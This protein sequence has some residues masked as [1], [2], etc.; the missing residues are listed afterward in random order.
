[1]YVG[2]K[3]SGAFQHSSFLR[4]A[5][6]SAA[7]LI[8]IKNGQLRKLSPL[9]GHYAPPM[10]NFREFVKSLKEE[11]AD[12]SHLHT[13]HSYAVLLGLESY[14]GA[15]KH[16][17]NAE[18]GMKDMFDPEG[19]RQREEAARDKSKSAERERQIL[20]Q[21]E[22]DKRKRSLSYRLRKKLGMKDDEEQPPI[23]ENAVT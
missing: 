2:I 8:K 16:A 22:Q 3:Q 21:Q 15:K 7:G 4:G 23:P 20:Q 19:K 9:S 18:Q 11:G 12:L 6:V 5:R 13:S 17:K 10:K 1:M 14:I